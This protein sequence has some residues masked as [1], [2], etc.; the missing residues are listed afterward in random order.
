[1][2]VF[3]KRSGS[4][5]ARRLAAC[6]GVWLFASASGVAQTPS[7]QTE[8]YRSASLDARGA[9]VI[10]RTDG[11]TVVVRKRG[12]QKSFASPIVSSDGS[13]VGA[14]AMFSN[15]C[16]SYDIPLELVVY[17]K[18][19][20]HRFR[21]VELPI[22][23]WAFADGGTRVAFGQEPV[24]FGCETHYELRDVKSGRLVE[25]ADVPQVCA[26]ISDPK[27]VTIPQWVTDLN[28]R[29]ER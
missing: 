10:A 11:R 1:M 22:F 18:G 28:S 13:A 27:A 26:Q 21:G 29:S 5:I 16:T 3:G 4:C 23:K 24:H 2:R 15:C 8:T 25:S 17:S 7:A 9:L 20:I 14:Q 6:V 19:K 12:E